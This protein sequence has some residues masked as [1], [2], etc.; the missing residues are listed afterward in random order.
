[1]APDVDFSPADGRLGD[2]DERFARRV[3]RAATTV[4]GDSGV[5]RQVRSLCDSHDSARQA[6]ITQRTVGTLVVAVVGATGQGK[7]WL[8]RQFLNDP[9]T[10]AAIP[11]GNNLDEATERLIWVGAS[12][13]TDI[14][15]RQERFVHCDPNRMF[16]LGVP[17]VLVD[18]PGATDDR[19]S[20]A[21]IAERALS[22]AG[23]LILVIRRD[24]L[25]SG[26]V[27][28]LAIASEGS[29]VVP[30]INAVRSRDDS[31]AAD[32]DSFLARIRHA[33][34]TS[35]VAAAVWVDDFA[36][37]DRSESDVAKSALAEIAQRITSQLDRTGGVE[38]RRGARLAALDLHFRR[39]LSRLMSD[40][41][42]ALT[43]AVERLREAA[44]ALP[45]EI[46]ETLVGGGPPLRAAVRS[47]LRA[48]L[49]ADTEAIWFPY[50]TM[51]GGLSLTSGAWDRVV[52]SLAGSLPSLI[53]AA[54]TS[55]RNLAADASGN[56]DMRD[57]L[58]RRAAAIVA[59]RLGPLAAR[60]RSE[61]RRLQGHAAGEPMAGAGGGY[62]A[63]VSSDPDDAVLGASPRQTVMAD[64]A[65][66]DALQEES[67]R[68]FDDEVQRVAVSGRFSLFC[69]LIGTLLFWML[70]A[71]PVVA[72]Y[73]SYGEASFGALSSFSGDLAAFPRP[74]LSLIFTSLLLSLLPTA[75]FAMLVISW[76]Q[77][78]WR[79][80]RAETEIRESHLR[81][82]R[83]L[84]QDRVLRLRWDDPLLADAEFLLSVDA[85]RKD[86]AE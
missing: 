75:I 61:L 24:Q 49:L 27:D 21:E 17:Y 9:H 13:P 3:R 56:R 19:R 34:P 78:R 18:A 63:D 68:I 36:L 72:L 82:I 84:Q 71:G 48:N 83:R 35:V 26:L 5:G 66:I 52:L 15:H 28:S 40:R 11:S 38:S 76:A 73:R 23:V 4:L 33:A 37:S 10:V 7:S 22:L 58:K 77:G 60:F 45:R 42:P 25:R 74:E 31:L 1:M 55:A 57:G 39:D 65:G 47:R 54:W 50:R 16:S 59:D 6:V 80:D 2:P 46:A 62:A 51:L 43:A 79:I 67:Q 44:D 32:T 64:L 30:V 69:S 12:P 86:I 70:M 8:L 20:I 14:D 53:G 41:L 81:A 29:I 85:D